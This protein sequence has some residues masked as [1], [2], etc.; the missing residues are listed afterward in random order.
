MK[1]AKSIPS[2]SDKRKN[3]LRGAATGLVMSGLLACAPVIDNRGYVFD[4]SLLPQ[5][6]VGTTS[7]ADIITIMGSP[8]TVSTLNGG[9]YYYI[10]SRFI[11]EA[12]RAPRETE[13]RVLA[14]FLDED[15]KIRDLGFYTLE[16]GNIVTI[17]A[18][19][20][21]TQGRELTFL[22]QIFGN[23]GRFESGDGSNF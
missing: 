16:D 17:V 2:P 18:R 20:T 7:E 4:E 9:A 21:E 1:Q 12:Y 10:S 15:K 11:T 23:L 3:W 14:I 6:V 13:R 5:L 22:Q 19:T 8:S